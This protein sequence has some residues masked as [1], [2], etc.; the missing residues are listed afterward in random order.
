MR[1]IAILLA[2]L[3]AA[4]AAAQTAEEQARLQWIVARGQ[5]LF[6]IDRAAWVAT[7]DLRERVS[8][9][10]LGLIRG[11]TVER[12]GD[13]LVVNFYAGEGDTRAAL[14]RARVENR[15]VVSRE[16]FAANAR[17]P[18]TPLQR[19]LADARGAIARFGERP[20][21]N[22]PFNAAII[23]PDTP[24]GPI[25]VYALTAQ[26][27]AASFPFGGHFR[28]TLAADGT[29]SGKRGFMRSCFM[30]PRPPPGRNG[31]QPVGMVISHLLDPIPTEIHVFMSIWMG[32]PV[33]VATTDRRV[34]SVEGGRISLVDR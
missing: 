18:L 7:D 25:D 20:C 14:Y 12:D 5:L 24:D 27:E 1:L 2:L 22:S 4:P 26:T 28:A 11:W 9:A 15:R 6:E 19:R 21:T 13:G 17:P 23:P 8:R 16:V 29:L 33:F 31:A 10:D 32:F 34:W 3:M 30:A